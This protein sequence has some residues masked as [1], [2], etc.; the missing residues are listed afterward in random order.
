LQNGF[1]IHNKRA[2]GCESVGKQVEVRWQNCESR[3]DDEVFKR[4]DEWQSDA[5]LRR[6]AAAHPGNDRASGGQKEREGSYKNSA[7][8]QNRI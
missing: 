7:D 2:S 5:I 8:E 3:I 6:A 4:K 1:S